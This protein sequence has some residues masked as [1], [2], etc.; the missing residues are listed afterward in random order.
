M[1]VRIRD[2]FFK[3]FMICLGVVDAQCV[4]P[5]WLYVAKFISSAM[6][7]PVYGGVSETGC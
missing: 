1:D 5:F 2:D 6:C 7:H 3:T 4:F